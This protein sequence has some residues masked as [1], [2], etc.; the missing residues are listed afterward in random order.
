MSK[1]FTFDIQKNR[2]QWLNHFSAMK[3]LFDRE[4]ISK[5]AGFIRKD[6][7]ALWGAS[8]D[9][10]LLKIMS[11]QYRHAIVTWEE[12]ISTELVCIKFSFAMYS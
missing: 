3:S 8:L 2:V 5:S 7:I 12:E 6:A 11:C 9:A 1:L 10:T 4:T